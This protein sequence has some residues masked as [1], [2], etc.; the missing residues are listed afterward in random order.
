MI[1]VHILF[2]ILC[3]KL[4]GSW[5][6][7]GSPFFILYFFGFLWKVRGVQEK[8]CLDFLDMFAFQ[9]FIKNLEL[10]RGQKAIAEIENF[11]FG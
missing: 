3:T 2:Y 6:G 9:I 7:L 4:T 11:P 5:V 8:V 1:N 10:S